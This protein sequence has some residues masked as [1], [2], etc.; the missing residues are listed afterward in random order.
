MSGKKARGSASTLLGQALK[1][2]LETHQ[3][4]THERLAELLDVDPK[5]ISRWKSG[6]AV[7]T[8]PYELKRIA[9]R[10]ALSYE[11]LAIPPAIYAPLTAKQIEETVSL[12]WT[13]IYQ[14]QILDARTTAENTLLQLHQ[15]MQVHDPLFLRAV[16]RLYNAAAHATSMNV[17]TLHVQQA[18]NRYQQMEQFARLLGDDTFLNIAL[19]YQGDMLRRRN[20]VSQA[21]DYLEAAGAT[22]PQAD[23]SARGNCMQ[24]L[25]RAYLQAGRERDFFNA[26]AEAEDLAFVLEQQ[27]A[28]SVKMYDRVTVYEEYARSYGRLGMAQKALDYLEK[29]ESAKPLTKVKEMLLTVARAEILIYAGDISTGEALAIQAARAC[30]E[31]GHQ[32]QLERLY[33]LKRFMSRQILSYGKAER[34]LSEALDGPLEF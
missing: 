15:H 27:A 10:L 3:G 23:A 19:T 22:T 28:P 31:S 2:Y 20:E 6:E 13:K 29:A 9:D 7:I 17:R 11:Q 26:M 5:T 25:G 24:L 8:D 4:A 32:R 1:S 12:I 21:L 16:T 30:K 33:A 18:M 34:A 14:T